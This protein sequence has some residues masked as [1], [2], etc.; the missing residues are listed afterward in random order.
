MN[1]MVAVRIACSLV[2]GSRMLAQL[3]KVLLRA[4]TPVEVAVTGRGAV[5]PAQVDQK[6]VAE[7]ADR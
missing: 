5:P 4:K 3:M 2:L 7:R 1:A 6:H